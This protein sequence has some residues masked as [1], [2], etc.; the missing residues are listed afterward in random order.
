MEAFSD[1]DP[2]KQK[3]LDPDASSSRSTILSPSPFSKIIFP[4]CTARVLTPLPQ[5]CLELP[6]HFTMQSFFP[7]FLL[8]TPIVLLPFFPRF[9]SAEIPPPQGV[10]GRNFSDPDPHGSALVLTPGSGSRVF[11]FPQIYLPV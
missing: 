11:N 3:I 4:P 9:A 2:P 10:G 6:F 1:P 5:Y 8:H 7:P